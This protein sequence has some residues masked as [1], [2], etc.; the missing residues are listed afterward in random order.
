MVNT[1][2]SKHKPQAI[3]KI[4]LGFDREHYENS[5]VK[6]LEI[7]LAKQF[8]RTGNRWLAQNKTTRNSRAAHDQKPHHSRLSQPRSHDL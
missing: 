2:Y 6:R 1:R 4:N 5:L 3:F 8:G 7:N